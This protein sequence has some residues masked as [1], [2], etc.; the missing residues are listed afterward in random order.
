MR[1]SAAPTK[2]SQPVS[3]ASG[4]GHLELTPDDY[5][6]FIR[7]PFVDERLAGDDRVSIVLVRGEPTDGAHRHLLAR[8]APGGRCMDRS[9]IRR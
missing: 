5:E 6:D 4:I 8:V 3:Y 1:T 7:S 2:R 9:R